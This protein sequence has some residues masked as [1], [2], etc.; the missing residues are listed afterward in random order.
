MANV[1]LPSKTNLNGDSELIQTF[2]TGEKY[3]LCE[4]R[5]STE[6]NGVLGRDGSL[7]W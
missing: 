2:Y 3:S 4:L 5:Q 6:S 1:E 7:A